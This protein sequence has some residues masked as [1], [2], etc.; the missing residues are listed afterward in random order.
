MPKNWKTYKLKDVCSKIGSG[1]TPR[2][3]KEAYKEE[4]ITLIRSQNVLDFSFSTN[5]LAF[6]DQTQ[7]DALKNVII[8]SRD[9]LINITGDSVARV[10][11]VPDEYIPARVNQHVAILRANEELLC[12]ELLKYVL[13]TPKYKD[14][15]LTLAS[16]G[17]TR[18]A[19]T[20]VML[21][22]FE[23]TIPESIPEQR[24]I[25]SILSSLDDKIELNLQTNKTL[26]EMAMTLY[27]HWFVD[28][29]PFK[30]GKFIDSELGPI[31]EGWEVKSVYSLATFI[32]G[33]AFKGK[34][35]VEDK[36]QGL[37]VIKIA[38]IKQGIT[39]QTM[40]SNKKLDEKYIIENGDI[41][42]PWSGNPHTSLGIHLWDKKRALLNQH[43]FVVRPD[44]EE[45]CFVFNS[46][47]YLLPTFIKLATHKQT[48]GLGHVTV[49][50]LKELKVP[51]PDTAMIETFN[52]EAG[53]IMDLIYSNQ[54]ENQTLTALRDTLLPKL[55]SGEVRVKDVEQTLSEVL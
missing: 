17:A 33:A 3:G 11:Q 10:C 43:I 14:L 54:I 9:V 24:A 34:D 52:Y 16:A 31:P 12:P 1:A 39:S 47:K 8:E 42:F 19:I 55:I 2:G 7:A 45:R 30:D 25:A 21:E 32:N 13:L 49:S 50:N 35:F 23:I 4:G 15:L 37:P 28:F 5:G 26:E 18:N 6:I 27:K 44:P 46:L 36:G 53:P 20:K 38:E 29:G 22:D 40:H 51:F 48:T 41:L